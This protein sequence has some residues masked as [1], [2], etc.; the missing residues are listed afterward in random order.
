[1][2]TTVK[3][4]VADYVTENEIK[5]IVQDEIRQTVRNFFADEKNAQRLLSNLSYQIVF[6]EVDK[7][8]PDCRNIIKEKTLEII[9]KDSFSYNVF[10]Q[11]SYG[12]PNS[13]AYDYIEQTVREC[14]DLINQKVKDTITNHDYSDEIWRKFEELGET[15]I[16]NIYSIVELGK[17]PKS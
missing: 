15:F 12:S 13:L 1:M 10:R 9:N 5:E 16:S 8:V 11:K 4:N 17:K 3:I 6:D 2:E 14:K 7:I